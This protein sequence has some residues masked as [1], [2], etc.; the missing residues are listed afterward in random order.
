M[1]W[2]DYKKA[3]DTAL[4]TWIID[5]LKMYKM[6]DD[7]IKFITETMKNWKVELTTGRK[8]LAVVK[9]QSSFFQG[10]VL[11][12]LSFVITPMTLNHTGGYNFT[13]SQEKIDHLIW[14]SSCLQK[15]MGNGDSDTNDKNKHFRCRNGI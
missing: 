4:Q 9:I 5:C 15:I 14:T 7:V 2:I 6:S 1:A 13:K 11:S 10:D 12:P 3:N 8:T